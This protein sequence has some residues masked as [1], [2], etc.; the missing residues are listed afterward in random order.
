MRDALIREAGECMICGCNEKRPKH[1]IPELNRLCCHE[2]ANGPSRQKALDAPASILV[3]C[4]YCNGHEVEDKGQWPE[5]RQLAVL[6]SKSPHH[7]DLA[8]HNF[9]VNPNAPRR[10]EQ[11]EVDYWI[12][13]GEAPLE[14]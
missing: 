7:Y 2:I 4:W 11:H 14:T 6:L 5:A 12:D 1:R 10:I 3:L 13:F 9:L 8:A